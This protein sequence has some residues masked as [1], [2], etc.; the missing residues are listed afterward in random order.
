[1]SLLL[2]VWGWSRKEWVARITA[3]APDRRLQ[4][5]PDGI[6]DP[7]AVEYALAWKPRPGLLAQ[8]PNLKVI[9]SLGAGVDHLFADPD[10]PDVPIVRIV[11]PSLTRRMTEW[12]VLQVL[13]HHRRQLDF[14]DWQKQA[15]WRQPLLPMASEVRVGM[16]GLGEL[17]RDAAA[18]LAHIGYQV[19]G[20]SRSRK[21]IAGIAY[22]HGDDGLSAFLARTD[23][24]VS[25]LPLTPETTG[26]L[27]YDL[28]SKLARDGAAPGPAFIN[29]GRGKSQVE[30]DIIRALDDGT[31]AGASIDV[32]ETEPL[33]PENPLWAHPRLILTPHVSAESDPGHLVRYVLDQIETFETGGDLVNLV[34]RSRG[35]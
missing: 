27:N 29:A 32:F 33:P 30:G 23:I 20:W 3:H 35:Y 13:M 15:E 10:L 25:L 2:A 22:F 26:I 8:F 18:M 6:A 11:D 31:L 21:D 9:F 19:A 12:V 28:F 1:M 17:G 5:A 24:L 34:D 4:V 14:L 16:M 7:Q